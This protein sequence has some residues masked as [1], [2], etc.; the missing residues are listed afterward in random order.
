[1]KTLIHNVLRL[2]IIILFLS[3]YGTTIAQTENDSYV[4]VNGVLK[5]AKTNERLV[6]YPTLMANLF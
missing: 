2:G 1:M 4:S 6:P 5:D 3:S